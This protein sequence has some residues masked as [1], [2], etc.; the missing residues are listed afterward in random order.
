MLIIVREA[1][2]LIARNAYPIARGLSNIER[3][4][5]DWAYK[6]IR[7]S[8]LKKP[9]YE[10]YKYGTYAGIAGSALLDAL[11]QSPDQRTDQYSKT[12]NNMVKSGR[13]RQRSQNC[14]PYKRY[15]KSRYR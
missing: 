7:L 12:R 14:R 2:R 4:A 10:G 15:R 9:I 11:S 3:P 6:G 8:R 13:K 5:F 1:I